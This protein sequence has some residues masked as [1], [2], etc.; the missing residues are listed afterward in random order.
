MIP[1]GTVSFTCADRSTRCLPLE[2]PSLVSWSRADEALSFFYLQRQ[3]RRRQSGGGPL[4][5]ATVGNSPFDIPGGSVNADDYCLDEDEEWPYIEILIDDAV[6]SVVLAEGQW[7]ELDEET[8]LR[9]YMTKEIKRSV[10]VKEGD[11]MTK[12]DLQKYPAEAAR[13][14]REESLGWLRNEC[15]EI[16]KLKEASNVFTSRY[17]AK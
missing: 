1:V 3:R 4:V 14:T 10:V 6:R 13:A 9:V 7:P 8:T 11:M 2:E 17:A 5:L 16:A 15:Y 12:K